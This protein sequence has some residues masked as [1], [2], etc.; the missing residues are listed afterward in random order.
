MSGD[1]EGAPSLWRGKPINL[2]KD[3]LFSKET[4]SFSYVIERCFSP[5][6]GSRKQ[7]GFQ[8]ITCQ[9]CISRA[10]NDPGPLVFGS[11][12]TVLDRHADIRRAEGNIQP[13]WVYFIPFS[14][15]LYLFCILFFVNGWLAETGCPNRATTLSDGYDK[16][17][18]GVYHKKI[19]HLLTGIK[20]GLFYE[21]ISSI[22][23]ICNM[24]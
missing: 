17:F 22:D 18:H 3:V 20:N 23:I 10:V 11:A 5:W 4:P 24:W 1:V 7:T 19:A 14:M 15:R 6:S 2:K 8:T 13:K 16:C 12:F 21:S 9:S